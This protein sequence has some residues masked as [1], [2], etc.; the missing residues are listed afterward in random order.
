[1]N[2]YLKML[3][4]AIIGN[5]QRLAVWKKLNIRALIQQYNNTVMS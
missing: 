5:I 2:E 4:A 3:Q 1:M